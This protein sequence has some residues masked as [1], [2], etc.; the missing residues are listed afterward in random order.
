MLADALSSLLSPWLDVMSGLNFHPLGLVFIFAISSICKRLS[1]C[2]CSC[3][4]AVRCV[5]VIFVCL[6]VKVE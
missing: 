6:F 3:D 5:S 1:V 2:W 4:N